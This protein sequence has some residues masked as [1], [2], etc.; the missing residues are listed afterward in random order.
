[1]HWTIDDLMALPV[2]YYEVLIEIA[3]DWLKAP[4]TNEF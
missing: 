3:P 2:D 4:D 1:M